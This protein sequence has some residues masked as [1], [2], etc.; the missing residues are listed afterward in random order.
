M[1]FLT[2]FVLIFLLIGCSDET[3]KKSTDTSNTK[4]TTDEEDTN[5]PVE[6]PLRNWVQ[7]EYQPSK[8]FANI[9]SNPRQNNKYQDLAGDYVDENNW[10]R[11]WSHETYLWYN[12]LPDINPA[13][14]QDPINY[15]DQMKTSA[16]T[17]SGS[18]KDRF[19]IAVD[20]AESELLS[21]T[22]ISV[23]YGASA[24]QDRETKRVYVTYTEPNSPAR[25]ANIS[26]GTEILA[27]DGVYI[28]SV[29][30]RKSA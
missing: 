10:I 7:N 18:A 1:R 9:C 24:K 25:N 23:G 22:G 15:F 11:S 26:R 21:E 4:E 13:A 2:I 8:N 16:I 17:N 20:T 12:E 6:I 3:V 27:A 29:I 28:G 5:Y 14:I 19:H 30:S